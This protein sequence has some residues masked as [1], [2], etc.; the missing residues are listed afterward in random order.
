MTPWTAARQAPLSMELFMQE[1]WSGLPFPS[2]GD[3]LN[4]GMEPESLMS[5]ALAGVRK[6]NGIEKE[7]RHV[8]GLI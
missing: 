8:E 1:C 3:L 5:P 6:G 7:E 4:P 2:A